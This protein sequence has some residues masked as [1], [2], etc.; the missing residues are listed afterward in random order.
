MGI[1]YVKES[2][3]KLV[4]YP[5]IIGLEVWMIKRVHE[6]TFLVWG[7]RLSPRV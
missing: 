5:T 2:S 3:S 6:V 1:K 4:S 7:Q